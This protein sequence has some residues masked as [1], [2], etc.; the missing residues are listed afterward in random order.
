ML[1]LV[2][3]WRPEG[4]PCHSILALKMKNLMTG[5]SRAI[6]KLSF[7]P[8]GCKAVSILGLKPRRVRAPYRLTSCSSSPI[9]TEFS[10]FR[11]FGFLT[12]AAGSTSSCSHN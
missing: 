6:P 3:G 10:M 1:R 2:I 4:F 5:S 9:F 12:S 7:L 8:A 11:G